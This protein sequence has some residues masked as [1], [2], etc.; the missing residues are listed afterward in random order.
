MMDVGFSRRA[1]AAGLFR[2]VGATCVGVLLLAIVAALVWAVLAAALTLAGPGVTISLVTLAGLLAS[3]LV[4]VGLVLSIAVPLALATAAYLVE[5][6]PRTVLANALLLG[7]AYLSSM[8]SI[9]TGTAIVAGWWLWGRALEFG[10]LAA[11]GAL[12]LLALP[13]LTLEYQQRLSEASNVYREATT[14][15]GI[16]RADALRELIIPDVSRVLIGAVFKSAA[17]LLGAVAPLAVLGFSNRD[18]TELMAASVVL[19]AAGEPAGTGLAVVVLTV[20]VIVI[21]G[22]ASLGQWLTGGREVA[23]P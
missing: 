20:M 22:L 7:V 17:R 3:S 10:L 9:L 18:S 2:A 21:L 16:G 1:F 15:L 8:P 13:K 14:A 19:K 6:A 4:L 12:L 5:Y 23:G 11:G